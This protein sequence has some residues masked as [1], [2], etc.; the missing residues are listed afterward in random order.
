MTDIKDKGIEISLS[1]VGTLVPV[2]AVLWFIIQPMMLRDLSVAM[3]DDLKEQ[4]EE[5]AAPMESAF[6]ILL[7]SDINATKRSI[8]ALEF[9]R[10]DNPDAWTA[11]RAQILVDN[12]IALLALQ[13]AYRAL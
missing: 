10:E 11:E 13:E 9:S 2:I 12:E 5:H 4:M 8:A 6:K 7:L 1:T 3:A